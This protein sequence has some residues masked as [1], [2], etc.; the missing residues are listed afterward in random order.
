MMWG[1]LARASEAS[2]NDLANDAMPICFVL[3]PA[4]G[5]PIRPCRERLPRCDVANDSHIRFGLRTIG[6]IE[7]VKNTGCVVVDK[8][9]RVC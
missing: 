5:C 3:V 6:G 4:L 1:T 2:E 9:R 7:Q 8:L